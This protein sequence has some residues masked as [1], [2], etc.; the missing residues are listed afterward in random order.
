VRPSS[1][2]LPVT[3]YTILIHSVDGTTSYHGDAYQCDMEVK[4]SEPYLSWNAWEPVARY[5]PV[6]ETI[7]F[8]FKPKADQDGTYLRI[9]THAK[10]T[11][12]KIWWAV[13]K[14]LGVEEVSKA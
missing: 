4:Y 3:G 12:K 11:R 1:I 10:G 6:A 5:S 13:R 7:S 2:T 9:I 14:L 8:T